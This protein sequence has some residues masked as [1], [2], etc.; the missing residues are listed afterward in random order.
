ME[1]RVIAPTKCDF[2]LLM[3]AELHYSIRE[4]IDDVVSCD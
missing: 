1:L 2:A 3:L 4:I